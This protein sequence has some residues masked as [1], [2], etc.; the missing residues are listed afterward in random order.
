MKLSFKMGKEVSK[1]KLNRN[2]RAHGNFSEY[3]P[4][5]GL[6]L[7]T[8]ELIGNTSHEYLIVTHSDLFFW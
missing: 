8:L 1:D 6:L 7:L 4:L 3:F 5:L 2:V